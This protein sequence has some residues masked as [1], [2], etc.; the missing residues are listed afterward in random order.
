MKR[1]R[2]YTAKKLKMPRRI[3]FFSAVAVLIVVFTVILGNNL[4]KKLA[5]APIDTSE[6]LSTT[7]VSQNKPVQKDEV[8]ES[9]DH[10]KAL[11]GVVAGYLDLLG[12]MESQQAEYVVDTIQNSGYNCA[13]FIVTDEEGKLTYASPEVESASRLPASADIVS[14]DVLAAAVN[15]AKTKG[16]R[17]SAVIT[18]SDSLSDTLVIK[19]LSALG[20]DEIIICGFEEYVQLDNNALKDITKYLDRA[21]EASG[22]GVDFGIS[23]DSEFF[24]VAQNAPYIEKL[25]NQTEFFA[26]DLFEKSVDEV[27]DLAEELQ[28]SFTAYLLRPLLSGDDVDR[29]EATD[30]ALSDL[31]IVARQY[32]SVPEKV[33]EDT[34]ETDE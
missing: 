32:V 12:I 3:I 9:V 13:A 28:G 29:K 15:R 23:F 18:A 1:Y 7:D 26:I 24:K 4:K 34:S 19:E 21:R 33:V 16:L 30:T 22:N 11:S 25:Y 10:D 14:Y 31:G 27:A 17:L 5:E 6:V 2:S 20:F 8:E